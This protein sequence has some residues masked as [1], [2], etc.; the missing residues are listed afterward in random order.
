M[1]NKGTLEGNLEEIKFVKLL[2]MK[3]DLLLWKILNLNPKN[4][5]AIHVTSNHF[6][7]LSQQK[8]MPK[9]DAFI[10]KGKVSEDIIKNK[11]YYLIES[12]LKDLN[13][14][15]V[16]FSG[17]SIKR[18]DSR[19]Y[20]ILKLTPDSFKKLFGSYELGA[21]ASLYSNKK[22][23]FNK[24]YDV[25]MGWKTNKEDFIDFFKKKDNL[26]ILK[27]DNFCFEDAKIIKKYS[28]KQIS[29]IIKNDKK[30]SKFVFQ[31]IGNFDEPFTTY[32]LYENGELL[33]S[34]YIPFSVT[35]GSGRS[36]GDYTIVLKPKTVHR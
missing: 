32:F 6:G 28:T 8:V 2:N 19:N 3:K 15:S 18:P 16:D 5:H 36:R 22:S 21:G 10:A 17:I 13:L 23:D 34:C 9:A 24:N 26:D 25:I 14:E 35:T 31:G 11:D 29:S 7:K 1:R 4:H 33:D 27:D 20:Q 30:I 12:D